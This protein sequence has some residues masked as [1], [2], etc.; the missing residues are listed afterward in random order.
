MLFARTLGTSEFAV[1]ICGKMDS[2]VESTSGPPNENRS[3]SV[4]SRRTSGWELMR[5]SGLEEQSSIG[6]TRSRSIA[7][8]QLSAAEKK[9]FAW[10]SEYLSKEI[11]SE[12]KWLVESKSVCCWPVVSSAYKSTSLP[13]ERDPCSREDI[14]SVWRELSTVDALLR[15]DRQQFLHCSDWISLLGP[16]LLKLRSCGVTPCI[17]EFEWYLSSM[18]M[19]C[20]FSLFE[21]GLGCSYDTSDFS[22][23]QK[24]KCN[25]GMSLTKLALQD[26]HMVFKWCKITT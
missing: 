26:R 21:S 12:S 24:I 17:E 9:K 3:F 18:V 10:S 15:S 11:A 23:G 2:G 19:V 6:A 20:S 22:S 14:S 4:G 7:P 16:P 25:F 13:D 8:C 1:S 5:R